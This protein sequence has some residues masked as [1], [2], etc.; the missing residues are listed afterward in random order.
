MYFSK[1]T[2]EYQIH[3]YQY[4]K[5]HV[6]PFPFAAI[7]GLAAAK[8]ECNLCDVQLKQEAQTVFQCTFSHSKK[9]YIV[10]LCTKLR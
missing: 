8:M 6:D 2:F 4:Q 7:T 5:S 3:K 9:D 10:P 1:R